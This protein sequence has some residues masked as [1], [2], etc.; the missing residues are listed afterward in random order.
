MRT[1]YAKGKKL[2]GAANQVVSKQPNFLSKGNRQ[3]LDRAA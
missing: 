2:I 1:R 3:L